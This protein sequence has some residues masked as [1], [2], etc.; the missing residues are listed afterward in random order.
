M[1]G[2]TQKPKMCS[3]WISSSYPIHL[4]RFWRRSKRMKNSDRTGHCDYRKLCQDC[5]H[6][7]LRFQDRSGGQNDADRRNARAWSNHRRVGRRADGLASFAQD[8]GAMRGKPAIGGL[9]RSLRRVMFQAAIVA[10]HHN[11]AFKTFADRLRAAGRPHK[12]SSQ[13]SRESL[14]QSSTLSPIRA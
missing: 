6:L 2:A 13:P 9:R 12:L 14:A 8:S 3:G 4:N 5:R 11:P 10:S 1:N 7:A